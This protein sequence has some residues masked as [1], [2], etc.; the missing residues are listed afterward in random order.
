MSCVIN[1]YVMFANGD[2][3]KNQVAINPAN[4]VFDAKRLIGRKFDD[5]AFQS[6]MKHWPFKVIQGEGARQ[7][8]RVG[9]RGE[10]KASFPR[11][12]L[13]FTWLSLCF[14]F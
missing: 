6:D 3:A 7:K 11:F 12:D 1:N 10:M 14:W 13:D 2:A 4:T 9:V 8:I 5:Q